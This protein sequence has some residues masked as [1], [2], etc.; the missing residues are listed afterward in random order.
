MEP[1]NL[2]AVI[3][4]DIETPYENELDPKEINEKFPLSIERETLSSIDVLEAQYP[5]VC[6][7]RKHYHAGGNF[8]IKGCDGVKL[9]TL[10]KAI[11]GEAPPMLIV[12]WPDVKK[13]SR[14]C[15]FNHRVSHPQLHFGNQYPNLIALTFSSFGHTL[16]NRP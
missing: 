9:A 11:R 13:N 2:A 10:N 1:E 7:H 5:M 3:Y 14:A 16:L 12:D 15:I 6:R 8:V 4:H